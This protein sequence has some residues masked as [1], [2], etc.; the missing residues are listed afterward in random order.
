MH[1][2]RALVALA[3]ATLATLGLGVSAA[4]AYAPSTGY[5]KQAAAPDTPDAGEP[6]GG[7][8]TKTPTKTPTATPT[9]TPTKTPTAT[10][11][12][13]PTKTPTATPT[14]T[15]T[16]T[17]TASPSVSPTA[18]EL[19]KT[20]SSLPVVIGLGAG[21]MLVGGVFAALRRRRQIFVP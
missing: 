3:V 8:P 18:P 15:A 13:T 9:K 4:A 20:G 1:L 10:P 7:K 5:E 11:T 19:P 14:K 12:K 6:G 17:P 16:K 2:R 21:L